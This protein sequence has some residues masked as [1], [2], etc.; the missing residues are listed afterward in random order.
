MNYVKNLQIAKVHPQG[1]AYY[2]IEFFAHLNFLTL[3]IKVLLIKKKYIEGVLKN[4][5]DRVG[6]NQRCKAKFF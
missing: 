5:L 3:F 1:V 6:R 2:L 4:T